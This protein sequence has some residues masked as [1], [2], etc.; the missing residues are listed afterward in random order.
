MQLYDIVKEEHVTMGK[1][2]IFAG[3]VFANALGLENA[4]SLGVSCTSLFIFSLSLCLSVCLSNSKPTT[5]TNE[6]NRLLL[7]RRTNP[8]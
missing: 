3:S 1:Q 5:P 2:A 4:K 8:P 6:T 7:R